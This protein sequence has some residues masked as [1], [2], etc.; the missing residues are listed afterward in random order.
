MWANSK[1]SQLSL[2]QSA[3]AIFLVLERHTVILHIFFRF[4]QAY[5]YLLSRTFGHIL[6]IPAA[7]N[8]QAI[9]QKDFEMYE[10]DLTYKWTDM[11]MDWLC[12]LVWF[13]CLA[14][15]DSHTYDIL[16]VMSYLLN[17]HRLQITMYMCTTPTFWLISYIS[18]LVISSSQKHSI[19]LWGRPL[20]S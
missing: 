19:S 20:Q 7:S 12:L 2:C 11:N 6:G 5:S 4:A 9:S 1:K 18:S 13:S 16:F 8:L 10:K 17:C 15:R 14:H 3:H